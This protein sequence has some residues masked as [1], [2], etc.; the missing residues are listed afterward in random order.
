M[1]HFGVL[2]L[3]SILLSPACKKAIEKQEEPA[4]EISESL[5]PFL[6]ENGSYW[7]YKNNSSNSLDSMIVTSISRDSF[8]IGPSVP[9]QGPSGYQE[10]Y[11]INY[12]TFP[13]LITSKEELLGYVI[14]KGHTA[15]G[16]TLLS[17]K[18]KGDSSLN[19]KISDI[20]DTLTIE[21]QTYYN[22]VKMEI[23]ADRYIFNDYNYYYVDSIGVVKKEMIVDDS[24]TDT[25]SLIRT[26][27]ALLDEI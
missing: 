23:S 12:T 17:S 7:V 15:G 9:G 10:V 11:T 18:T 3:L 14:T 6:F 21:N 26:N 8:Q 20:L 25:W 24:I 27:S 22:V 5:H 4:T 2:F 13:D 1:R 16:Y 19:A